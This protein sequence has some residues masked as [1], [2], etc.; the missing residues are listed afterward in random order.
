MI[1]K[2]VTGVHVLWEELIQPGIE[3]CQPIKSYSLL[4][5]Y[6]ISDI[7]SYGNKTLYICVSVNLQTS[8]YFNKFVKSKILS[9]AFSKSELLKHL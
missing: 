9:W 6:W 7:W 8:Y 1:Y 2:I 5:L 3:C 4:K